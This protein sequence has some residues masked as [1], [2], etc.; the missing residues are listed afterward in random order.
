MKTHFTAAFVLFFISLA[1]LS[2]CGG[3]GGQTSS[4][5]AV[6]ASQ[7]CIGCHA[8]NS[9]SISPV[10]GESI[11]VEWQRSIHKSANGAGC[12]D[13]HAQPHAVLDCVVCHTDIHQTHPNSC[14][15]CHGGSTDITA[16]SN[17]HATVHTGTAKQC[18]DCH[19]ALGPPHINSNNSGVTHNAQ[20]LESQNSYTC[21]NCHNP[22]DNTVLSAAKAWATSA[23]GDVKGP[24]WSD[25]DFKAN[26]SCLR[27]HTATGYANYVTGSPAFT[28]PIAPLTASQTYGVLS[29]NACHKNYNFTNHT[30]VRKIP[31]YTAPY[32]NSLSPKTFP[33]VGDS[34]LCIACHSAR[35]SGDTILAITTDLSNTG[36]KNPHYM[37]AAATM[38]MSNAFVNFTTQTTMVP[39][40]NENVTPYT[41]SST[42][43]YATYNQPDNLSVPSYGISGGNSSA[44]RRIG[45]PLITG[46][47]NYLNYPSK[48]S[49][50]L[51]PLAINTNGPCVTCHMQANNP[52]PGN[53]TQNSGIPV[54]AVRPGNGHSLQIDDA[55]AQQLCLPCHADAPHLDGGDGNGNPLTTV[56]QTLAQ[57]QSAMLKPQSKCYQDGLNLLKQILKVKYMINYDDTAYPYFFDLQKDATGKTAVTDWTRKNVAG[58]TDAAVAALGSTFT[59]IQAGGLTQTQAMRLM[60]AC[61]NLNLLVKDPGAYVHARTFSQRLVYDALDFLDNNTM[62]FTALTS[63]RKLNPAIYY[64]TNINVRASDGSLATESMIWMSGTH[65]TDPGAIAGVG[66]LLKPMKLHP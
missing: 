58:V 56:I 59:P 10:T 43:T 4:A 53:T 62:D 31:T 55:T 44:H 30:S 5:S 45:T 66:T 27:C 36:F 41:Y 57:L 33:N 8:G 7:M 17:C 52:I 35:E 16:C 28:L 39:T 2:G 12:Y 25:E 34:N 23:H 13:C 26:T 11:T 3:D 19:S 15:Q 1:I 14:G 65:Y 38:Y 46:S 50:P 48:T 32:N 9:A 6:A 24:A 42:K 40:N 29:C 18:L 37:A 49:N 60:G 47:E 64:G 51:A 63:A 54:P 21:I 20:F 61:F 22:H